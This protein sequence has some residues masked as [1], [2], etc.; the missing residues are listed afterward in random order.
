MSHI[1]PIPGTPIFTG[2][3]ARKGYPLNKMCFSFN[4]KANREAF[5]ADEEG[6]MDKYGLN[7]DQKTGASRP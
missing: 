5:L 3:Q 2:A 1:D 6:Y 7:E 4:E